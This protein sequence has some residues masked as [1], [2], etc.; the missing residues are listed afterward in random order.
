MQLLNITTN[1]KRPNAQ[2]LYRKVHDRAIL[3]WE[4]CVREFIMATAAHVRIDTGMSV[5][6]LRPIANDVGIRNLIVA[7][8]NGKGPKRG[9][10][11]ITH[12]DYQD[13][14]GDSKSESFGEQLGSK[15]DSYDISFGSPQTPFFTFSFRIAIFQWYLHETVAN[16]NKSGNW[17]ALEYGREAFMREWDLNVGRYLNFQ[18]IMDSELY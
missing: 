14:M 16:Y 13:N 8:F 1:I 2:R 9:H 15:S 10:K 17:T 5:A 7:G 4:D 11:N 3:L 12:P 6:S 18:T